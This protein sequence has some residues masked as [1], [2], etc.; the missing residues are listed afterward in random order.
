MEE[1]SHSIEGKA[2]FEIRGNGFS[3]VRQELGQLAESNGTTFDIDSQ[4][5]SKIVEVV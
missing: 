5:F 1:E 2:R 4:I 3:R